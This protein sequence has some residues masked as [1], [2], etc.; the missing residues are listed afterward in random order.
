MEEL[1][2]VEPEVLEVAEAEVAE[3]EEVVVRRERSASLQ[4][5]RGVS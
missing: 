5:E 4:V 2:G 3:A 1:V